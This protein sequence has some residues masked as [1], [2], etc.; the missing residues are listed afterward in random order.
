MTVQT[1]VKSPIKTIDG[2]PEIELKVDGYVASTHIPNGAACA[3]LLAAGIGCLFLGLMTTGAEISPA[4]KNM[5]N[6][7]NPVGPLAGKTIVAVVAYFISWAVLHPQMKDRELD[8]DRYFM[9]SM[10]LTGIGFVL[11]FPTVFEYF[12]AH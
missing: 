11:T 3:A 2:I 5:L 10:V 1:P 6:L 4:L 9:Y 7:Y 8:F 12:T